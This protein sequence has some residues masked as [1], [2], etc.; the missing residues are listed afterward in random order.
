VMFVT[1]K[2]V[3]SRTYTAENKADHEKTLVIEHPLAGGS[4]LVDTPK[5]FETTDSFYR[6]RV[7]APAKKTVTFVVKEQNVIEQRLA[8]LPLDVSQLI[9]YSKNAEIPANVR[10]SLGKA[11]QLKQAM[12]DIDRQIN[13][14]NS[15]VNA[16]TVEQSRIRE[17]M[18]TVGQ[19]SQYYQRL[20]EKLNEQESSIEK[21][22]HDRDDLLAKRDAARKE[23]ES[24]LGDLSV[25]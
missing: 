18:K 7:P 9:F 4:T 14:K 8:L 10:A 19:T 23:L 3:S 15:Q 21:L 22:Q 2:N 6:F 13:D 16:I 12:V 24:Y 20:L 5:P 25:G 11:I 17:N 1:M